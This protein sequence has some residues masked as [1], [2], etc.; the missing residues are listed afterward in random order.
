MIGILGG[1]GFIG[2]VLCDTI[3]FKGLEVRS[4]SRQSVNYYE[5][6]ALEDW[7]SSNQIS[8]LINAAGYT[9]RPNVDACEHHKAECLM[10]NAVLPG[11]VK[12]ACA[13]LGLP[14]GHISSGCIYQ[15]LHPDDRPFHEDDLPNFCFRTNNCS[16]Y[17]G[18]KA[19]GEEVL[20]DAERC[21]VWRLRI[22][23]QRFD[24]PRNYISKMMNYSRLLNARNSLTYLDDF[25]QSCLACIH[26]DVP[27]GVYNLT[28]G[29]SVST[30]EVIELIKTH[31]LP[32]KEF[33]FFKDEA[34]FMEQAAITPRSNT[35]LD[36]TK[37]LNAGLPMRPV[38]QALEDALSNWKPLVTP[39]ESGQ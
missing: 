24:H 29:G 14:W 1:N 35:V 15:G 10:G 25:A 12:N 39:T 18:T 19:L 37:A 7:L 21:Y 38:R 22:P 5:Q 11:I 17:S 20:I 2:K 6:N 26:G 34:E 8:F 13:N 27:F 28:N 16:F 9:G 36:N 33:H 23:F 32:E 3:R 30:R 4:L 31:L